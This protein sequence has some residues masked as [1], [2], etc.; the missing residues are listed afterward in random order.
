MKISQRT[1]R[2]GTSSLLALSFVGVAYVLSGPN[3]FT[4]RTVSAE[5]AEELLAAYA[6]K[7]TDSD[8]LSDWQEALYGTDPNNPDTDGDGISDGEAVRQGLI[9]PGTLAAQLP[10]EP[11]GEEL[12]EEI[13]GVDPAPGSIT[14]QFGQEF[15]QAY[16]AAS[17]GAPMD[18]ATQQ[19]LIT[20]LMNDFSSR[21]A[22]TLQSRYSL[23]SIR[24]DTSVS[25]PAYVGSVE[26]I[27]LTNNVPEDASNPII[28]M[29]SLIMDNDEAARAKIEALAG[30]YRTV[31]DQLMATRVPPSLASEHLK[32][33]QGYDSMSRSLSVIAAYEEDPMGAMGALKMI[34][35]AS[36]SIGEAVSSLALRMLAQG[37]PAPDAAGSFVV[38][39]A[40]LLETSQN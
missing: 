22:A 14:E 16:A 21:V 31:A 28:L 34:Q 35:D 26:I 5:T 13:P 24:T 4:Q 20:E 10:E 38:Y 27:L 23:V 2:I 25:L 15:L 19:Q 30:V 32:I 7:D 9:N 39:L 12:L 17:N 1:L 18:E 37:E 36:G 8:T 33:A 29:D 40:R 11:T 6:T 3:L